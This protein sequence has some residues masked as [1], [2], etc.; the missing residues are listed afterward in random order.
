M[1]VQSRAGMCCCGNAEAVEISAPE[2]AGGA[3]GGRYLH[4]GGL[5]GPADYADLNMGLAEAVLAQ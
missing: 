4:N 3:P 1:A 2:V 5:A